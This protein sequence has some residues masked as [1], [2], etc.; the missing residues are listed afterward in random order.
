MVEARRSV[1]HIWLVADGGGGVAFLSDIRRMIEALGKRHGSVVAP[2][3]QGTGSPEAKL[4]FFLSATGSLGWAEAEEG[5]HRGQ[6]VPTDSQTGR[7]ETSLVG[8]ELLE[9][10]AVGSSKRP[11]GQVLK[12]YNYVQGWVVRHATGRRLTLAAVLSGERGE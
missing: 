7:V 12:T 10:G 9:V 6:L 8:V 1:V 5:V 2:S 3:Q 4:Q 11:V